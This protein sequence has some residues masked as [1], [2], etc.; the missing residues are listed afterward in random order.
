MSTSELCEES[1]SSELQRRY[2]SST[3]ID[4]CLLVIA[5]N[6]SIKRYICS[7]K[8]IYA[9]AHSSYKSLKGDMRPRLEAAIA[10]GCKRDAC[11]AHP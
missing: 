1:L 11:T 3:K 6:G 9:Q 8:T 2:V 7:T 5:C 4:I 10:S